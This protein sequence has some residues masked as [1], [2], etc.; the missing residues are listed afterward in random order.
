[1]PLLNQVGLDNLLAAWF[2]PAG[3]GNTPAFVVVCD[4]GQG[5]IN[6]IFDEDGHPFLYYDFGSPIKG[7]LFTT[8]AP[9]NKYCF[10]HGPKFILS[11]WDHDHFNGGL[12][13]IE[14]GLLQNTEWLA[15]DQTVNVGVQGFSAV[16][17]SMR[18]KLAENGRTRNYVVDAGVVTSTRSFYTIV[19][20]QSVATGSE[21]MNDAGLA[22]RIESPYN[23]GQYIFLAGD[24]DYNAGVMTHGCDTSAIAIT[25]A[26]HGADIATQA[27]IP[28]PLAQG[29][30]NTTRTLAYSFGWG[31][32]YGHPVAP[33]GIDT[34]T[35]RNW[36][37]NYRLDT[38][39]SE[40][41]AEH[42]GPRGNVALLF[43]GTPRGCCRPATA[44]LDHIQSAA[45]ALLASA[46]A[47]LE[48][49][50]HGL[51]ATQGGHAVAAAARQAAIE[52]LHPLM[53]D[54][55]QFDDHWRTLLTSA[56]SGVT[57]TV[58][59]TLPTHDVAT[60]AIGA[61]NAAALYIAT[62]GGDLFY[63]ANSGA[64]WANIA[65][66]LNLKALA[67]PANNTL[68]AVNSLRH[69]GS[70]P[71]NAANWNTLT[72]P[73]PNF[74]AILRDPA[75]ATGIFAV[76]DIGFLGYSPDLEFLHFRLILFNERG[77]G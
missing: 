57:W 9:E 23:A 7:G 36:A 12:K 70:S 42:P 13:H 38:G 44:R 61:A 40:V 59:R 77:G 48:L 41:E 19:K 53:A 73:G 28:R 52:A 67:S 25:A 58:V 16:A 68:L 60:A 6:V 50:L 4:I 55:L 72:G 56:D 51:G 35:H 32:Q 30:V 45:V 1:M 76:D 10:N 34:Y 29:I 3:A 27:G 15:P 37:D 47:E 20:G 31:N 49:F 74:K 11:H 2:L 8:G 43:P 46:A 5:N 62:N 22:L 64:A 21:G 14:R 18:K 24:M 66:P 75:V 71:D 39:G 17:K 63:S 65:S 26:H 69:V 54:A 33:D